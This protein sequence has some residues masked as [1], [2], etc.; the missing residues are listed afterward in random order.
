MSKVVSK[1]DGYW[2]EFFD[3]FV[4]ALIADGYDE[5]DILE[6]VVKIFKNIKREKSYVE[7]PTLVIKSNPE[8]YDETPPERCVRNIKPKSHVKTN[9]KHNYKNI[10]ETLAGAV[11]YVRYN[12]EASRAEIIPGDNEK[13]QYRYKVIKTGKIYNESRYLETF[14]IYTNDTPAGLSYLNKARIVFEE[15]PLVN[16][17]LVKRCYDEFNSIE[18]VK[19]YKPTI[20]SSKRTFK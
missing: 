15:N 12:K 14:N 3:N 8:V 11:V 19:K 7:S 4:K 16:M 5:F 13:I 17:S 2:D 18:D 10:A 20:P 1:L 9:V 6:K